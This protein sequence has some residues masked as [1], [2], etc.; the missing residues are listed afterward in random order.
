MQRSF[1]STSRLFEDDVYQKLCHSEIGIIG[2]GGVG[3]WAAEAL[4]RSGIRKLVLIDCDHVSESN[5]NR[6]VQ[7][8]I[9][10]LGVPKI[11]A[12]SSRLKKINPEIEINLH[13]VFFSKENN[14]KALNQES[15]DFWIDACD[16]LNAKLVLINSFKNKE[17][18]KKIL[19]CGG[20]GGKTDPFK[21]IHSDLY[22]TTNDP[23][24]SKLRYKL[25]REHGFPREKKMQIPV[26]SS[27]QTLEK[28]N[29][30]GSS[31]LGCKGY[32]SIVTITATFGMKASSIAISQLLKR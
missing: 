1:V 6:Q 18:K 28:Q 22:N 27:S 2:L 9:D 11:D 7:A 24:L 15:T 25:R 16:D 23:L 5:I 13:E 17:R 4:A 19:I 10:T 30:V 21:I 3:S 26:L 29:I 31:R 20:A 12:L 8:T 32:G 14:I